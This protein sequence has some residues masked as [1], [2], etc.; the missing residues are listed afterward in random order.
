[1]RGA[2]FFRASAAIAA[3]DLRLE[4]RT[5]DSLSSGTVFALM[6]AWILALTLTPASGEAP[7]LAAARYAPSALWTVVA[8]AC[9]VSLAPAFRAERQGDAFAGLLAAP[10]DRGAIYLGK[11]ASGLVHTALLAL[12]G[13]GATA[14]LFP[15]NPFERPATLALILGLHVL[16]LTVLGTL[17]SAIVHRVGRGEAL[18][19]TLLFPTAAPL[20]LSAV[21]CTE[22]STEG[23]LFETAGH[24]LGLT[25]GFDLL[26]LCLGL[27]VFEFVVED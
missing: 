12:L 1:M 25:A 5:W 21:R 8:F 17:F 23:R 7:E 18:L 10:I 27:L 26:Y 22:A 19:A 9:A 11:L 15:W 2:G 6:V 3:K 24:W 14:A 4:W 20:L 16:G 13:A